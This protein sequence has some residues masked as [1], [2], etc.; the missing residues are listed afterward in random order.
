LYAVG[1]E[2]YPLKD[3]V[4]KNIYLRKCKKPYIMRYIENVIFDNVILGGVKCSKYPKETEETNL[5]TD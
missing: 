4:L 1:V 3:I 5:I 2:D